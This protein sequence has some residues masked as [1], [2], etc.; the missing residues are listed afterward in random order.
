MLE[1][2]AN[3]VSA[4]R[5]PERALDTFQNFFPAVRFLKSARGE[6]KEIVPSI[7]RQVVQPQG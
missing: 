1:L 7:L 6:A 2:L 3:T 5:E 4:R